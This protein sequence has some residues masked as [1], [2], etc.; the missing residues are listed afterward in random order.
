MTGKDPPLPTIVITCGQRFY[1]DGVWLFY[2]QT[3]G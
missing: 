2:L 1:L 3:N